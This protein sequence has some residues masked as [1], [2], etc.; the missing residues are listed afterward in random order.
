MEKL[1]CLFA[2]LLLCLGQGFS[3]NVENIKDEKPV[4]FAG[5]ISTQA[6]FYDVSGIAPRNSPFFWNLRG[7]A[8]VSLWNTIDLPFSF[9]LG[10]TGSRA[11]YPTFAQFGLSPTYKWATVHLGYRNLNFS[12]YTLAGHTFL[13]AGV[14]L[15]PGKF[16]FSAMYGRLRNA[17]EVDTTRSFVQ[18][19][20]KRI[21]YGT[22]VGYGTDKTYVDFIL[23]RGKDDVNSLQNEGE[24]N[25]TPSENMVLGLSSQI[26]LFND[27]RFNFDLAGSA[28]TRN[29]NSVEVLIDSLDNNIGQYVPEGVFTTKASTRANMAGKAG[30]TYTKNTFRLNLGY[31]RIDPEYETMGA[32]FFA[33]DLERFTVAPHFNLFK[34]KVSLGGSYGIQ[35][36]NLLN[37]RLETTT[38]DIG[39]AVIDIHPNPNYGINLNFSNYSIY[40]RSGTVELSDTLAFNLST[41]NVSAMPRFTVQ[42]KNVM[43]NWTLV[44]NYQISNQD[45]KAFFEQSQQFESTLLS[46]HNS[47]VFLGSQMSLNS[48]LNYNAFSVADIETILYGGTLG[49]SRPFKDNKMNINISTSYNK[50]LLNSSNNGSTVSAYINYS[51]QP[52]QSHAFTV[53]FGLLRSI[54]AL[55]YEFSELRG[56]VGYVYRLGR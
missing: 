44:V 1:T 51:F 8:T 32:Y 4:D 33:N 14:E 53:N 26:T 25:I 48:G 35:R 50:R 21:G 29:L 52:T 31:E 13:G 42:G 22:K 54:G 46:L 45:N 16:R 6:G 24:T 27:L 12:P 11:N 18:P 3:Q 37:N 2:L 38:R 19:A 55:D 41:T 47:L 15:K 23:F 43:Q 36:N 7:N 40:Q 28:F 10:R 39:S 20:F 17:A 9:T 30:L 5:S 56:T 49:L 34:N